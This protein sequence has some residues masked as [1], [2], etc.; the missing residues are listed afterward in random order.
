MTW[1]TSFETVGADTTTSKTTGPA[2]SSTANTKGS[3][4]EL[5][6]ATGIAAW[7]FLLTVAYT[8]TATGDD[9]LYDLATGAAA[10][11]VDILSNLE[12]ST[13]TNFIN[14]LASTLVPMEI[15]SGTRISARIQNTS[16]SVVVNIGFNLT[17]LEE[18]TYGG[19]TGGVTTYGASTADSGGVSVDPGGTAHTKGAYSQ[20]TATTSADHSMFIVCFGSQDNQTMT[21]CNWLGDMA[22]GAA[23][24]EV[25][26]IPNIFQAA[27]TA[28]DETAAQ[29]QS[30][31]TPTVSSGT[32][33]AFRTQC[34]I[35]DAT[36][37]LLDVVIAGLDPP[38]PAAPAG[39]VGHPWFYRRQMWEAA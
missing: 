34:S 23:A 11:E 13:G 15:A 20:V 3:Y 22:T 37:R 24:S 7:A 32:R 5:V 27:T 10:S 17:L 16:T 19:D 18:A 26:L 1:V 8:T 29:N 38:V 9:H 39:P 2:S 25:V 14:V 36:D 21:S 30:Y 31:F 4:T 12:V 28:W 6:A 33:L 35:T